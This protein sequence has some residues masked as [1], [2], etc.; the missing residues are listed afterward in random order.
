MRSLLPLACALAL[1]SPACLISDDGEDQGYTECGD[2]L[3]GGVFES[4]YCQ[5]GQ[6]CVDPTFSECA[7]GCLSNEN[8]AE[9]QR[10]VKGDGTNLG[11]CQNAVKHPATQPRMEQTTE[12]GVTPC[13][14]SFGQAIS[15]QPGQFCADQR[16]SSCELGCLSDFN[17]ADSQLCIKQDGEDIGSCQ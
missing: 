7:D 11:T 17:C 4:N 9:D 14:T 1:L 3:S 12:G 8:C 6:Y 2:F 15:C 10:C 13:G 5:P 16:I